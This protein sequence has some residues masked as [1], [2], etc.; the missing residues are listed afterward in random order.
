[1]AVALRILPPSKGTIKYNNII[2]N[3]KAINTP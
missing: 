2:G 3:P 1:M